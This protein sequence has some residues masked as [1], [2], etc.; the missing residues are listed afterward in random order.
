MA[1]LPLSRLSFFNASPEKTSG[2]GL[3]IYAPL[4]ADLGMVN[5]FEFSPHGA[6]LITTK[7]NASNYA[8]D[9]VLWDAKTGTKLASFSGY[10]GEMSYYFSP[11]D[12]RLVTRLKDD[13]GTLWDSK[14]GN[15][16]AN[17]GAID[18]FVTFW[19]QCMTTP[20]PM[21]CKSRPEAR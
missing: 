11:D 15:K 7:G 5:S 21:G 18:H 8:N 16:L 20:V 19:L 9:A 17:L 10:W 3:S 12:A 14:A 1:G 13:A 4:V 6:F 2:V